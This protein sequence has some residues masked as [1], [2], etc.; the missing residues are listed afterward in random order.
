MAAKTKK[1]SINEVLTLL[2]KIYGLPPASGRVED[3]LIDHLLVATMV[4]Y[5]D[6]AGA[7]AIVRSLSENFLD[8]NEAR[9]SPLYELEP[10]LEPHVKKEEI[11]AAAWH[12]RMAMQDAW[13]GTHGLDLEP[14]RGVTPE[15]Q[16][17]FLK[18]LPNIPGGAAA[19]VFQIALGEKELAF[20]P[21]E[22]HL[23]KRLGMLPR[24]NTRQRLRKAVEK[25][26]KA[27]DRMR[28]T[29]LFGHAA[30]L[31]EED[32][33]P[34]H[35][36]CKLL[37][38]VG[39]RELVVREQE[40]KREEARR[41]AEEKKRKVEEERQRKKDERERIKRERE[42]AKQARQDELTA[43][44]LAAIAEKKAAAAKKKAAAAAQKKAAAAQKKAASAKKKAASA[45]TK[46]AAATKKAA[47]AT[48]K[49]AATK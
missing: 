36:F 48:S 13:D 18:H 16:R 46:A 31:F 45:K 42:E 44:K 21:L 47:A 14:M 39:A 32:F 30:N 26:V 49:A 2:Q 34:K 3:P 19:I 25:Q 28:F 33:D 4:T 15:A 35:P 9:V 40:R 11:R 6:E 22:E 17:E 1:P 8:F 20:G 7:R 12:L 37:V 23:L 24:S 43:K 38:K 29:W 5:T 41:I 27:A 10:I